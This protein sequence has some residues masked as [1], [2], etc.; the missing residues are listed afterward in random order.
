ML[1]PLFYHSSKLLSP[2]NK[3][4]D[5]LQ[6]YDRLGPTAHFCLEIMHD[7]VETLITDRDTAIAATG[8]DL[9]KSHLLNGVKMSYDTFSDKIC[10]VRRTRGSPLGHG[11][12]T[13]SLISA[14]V[15]QKVVQCLE[16]FS[17]DQL[18]DMWSSFS[19]FGD[20]RGMTGSIF[21]AFIHRRFRTRI[22]LA[23]TPMLRSNRANSR[24]HAS[25]STKRPQSATV[26]GVAN[27][28]FSLQVDVGRTF[29]YNTTTTL[30][31]QPDVYYIPRSGQQVAPDSFM[32][33]GGYL[34][35]YQCA[36]GRDHGI[37]DG[38]VGFFASCSGLPPLANWRF[39]FVVPDDLDSFSCPASSNPVVKDIGLYTARIPMSKP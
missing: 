32:L 22:D 10:L 33:S 6:R 21:E 26:H 18:L 28:A 29:V 12:Y 39:V 17:D 35:V 38:L 24:W 1:S 11:K 15:E 19:N 2:S 25:F 16:R 5:V 7:Q 37:K 9:L 14:D 31:I 30:N 34:D 8:P 27:Q 3:I 4:D 20:A 13:A 23:A 36:G